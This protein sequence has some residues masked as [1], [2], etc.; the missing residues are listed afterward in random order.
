MQ[1]DVTEENFSSVVPFTRATLERCRETHLLLLFPPI[2]LVDV[3]HA[4]SRS[5]L[6]LN[7]EGDWYSDHLLTRDISMCDVGCHLVLRGIAPLSSGKKWDEQENYAY[8]FVPEIISSARV[9]ILASI[10]YFLR[11]GGWFFEGVRGRTRTPD[12]HGCHI[13][14]GNTD[15]TL[16][17]GRIADDSTDNNLGLC[18]EMRPDFPELCL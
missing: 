13:G 12:G 6:P 4:I 2:H 5:P 11:T 16:G 9:V 1:L 10:A 8:E 3:F 7:W 14:V 18:L 15:G 17:I